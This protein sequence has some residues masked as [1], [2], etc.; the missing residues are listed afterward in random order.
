MY[1]FYESN[2]YA[3]DEKKIKKHSIY[4]GLSIK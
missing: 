3:F 1:N 4:N 2:T